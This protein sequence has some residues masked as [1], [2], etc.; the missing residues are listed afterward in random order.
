MND[1]PALFALILTLAAGFLLISEKLRP[2]VVGL[3]V[4]VILG[5]TRVVPVEALF[6][7]F[8]GSAV[9]TI[10][11]V[12]ILS[13]GLRQTG[14]ARQLGRGMQWIGGKQEARLILVSLLASAGL[15]LFMN[16]IAAVGV[17][18]P[19]VTVL[20]R[21]TRF[22]AQ[23][24]MMPLAYGVLL[25]GMA[26]L[27]TTSN[28]IVSSALRSAGYEPFGLLDFFPIGFPIV[29]V[30]ALYMVF[31]GRRLLPLPSSK[32]R[33]SPDQQ[34]NI[35]LL[36]L[37]GIEENLHHIFVQ[38]GSILAGRD[39]ANGQWY[40]RFGLSVVGL[41]RN[42]RAQMAPGKDEQVWAED[43]VL[44]QGIPNQAMLAPYGLK[45]LGAPT[46]PMQ[47]TDDAVILAEVVL[48][49][50]NQF[51]GKSLREIHFREKYGFN[52]LAFWREGKPLQNDLAETPL[53]Y[54]D[55]LLV[56][57][58]ASQ[59][60]ML[61]SE[62]D[63][64]V[65]EEDSDPIK[66]PQKGWLAVA[67]TTLA[68]LLAATDLLPMAVAAMAGAVGLLLSNCLSMEDAYRA[69]E[70]KAI[71]LIAGMWPLSTAILSSGLAEQV[72]KQILYFF[73]HPPAL[74]L[75]AILLGITFVLT[76][77]MGGQVASLVMAPLAIS[78]A[79]TLG[80]DARG[81]GMAVA[82][83]CS[84]AFPSP[85]GHPVNIVVMSAGG[86]T[87]KDYLRV[88]GPLTILVAILILFGLHLFW[89]V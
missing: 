50:H 77:L 70:W 15:S 39:I 79:Q 4:L 80:I 35:A 53:H 60:R 62:S 58:H 73:G 55:A 67:I 25:G 68:L 36:N 9:M 61:R 65:L 2:D 64:I 57:G 30:G 72:V 89:N 8:S 49:P 24:L 18:L 11:G 33:T 46:I 76:Q 78:A 10:L 48:A 14:V 51:V 42:G 43:I 86:Y 54:G 16:N 13:E 44:A 56:Q 3:L 75:A 32:Q 45:L 74:V 7:G 81:M 87:F 31:V 47:V 34:L 1:W 66:N 19:A 85:F 17:L 22:S 84:L 6:S 28:I 40:Q 26:T 29:V 12:S 59:L 63:F 27:L 21:Q 83:A 88:G 69:I 5:L 20:S 37:Y 41:I 23:R 82:L 52:V 38:P 71:F